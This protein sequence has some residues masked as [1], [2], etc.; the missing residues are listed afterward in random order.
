MLN[1]APEDEL[2]L[3]C[4]VAG[5]HNFCDVFGRDSLLDG[6]EHLAVSTAFRLVFERVRNDGKPVD[7]LPP[8]LEICIVVLWELL[9]DQMS[10][11]PCDHEVVSN[12]RVVGLF[13]GSKDLGNVVCNAGFLRDD[14]DG[15]G[16]SG[17]VEPT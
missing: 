5:V 1:D 8:I 10:D 17:P 6:R 11:G 15:H 9:F 7:G 3:A 16:W 12:P 4:C 13:L 2:T 14:D